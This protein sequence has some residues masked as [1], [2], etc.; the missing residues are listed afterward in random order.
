MTDLRCGNCRHWQVLE[1][2]AAQKVGQC[3]WRSNRAPI[4]TQPTPAGGAVMHA[5]SGDGCGAWD[6]IDAVRRQDHPSP[7]R[8]IF[9]FEL[10]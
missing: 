10:W 4:W 6:M 1:H 8:M 2:L 9:G 5:D 3:M 7:Y